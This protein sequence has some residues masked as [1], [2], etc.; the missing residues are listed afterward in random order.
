MEL[1]KHRKTCIKRTSRS[2]TK[3]L[4]TSFL[5]R[6]GEKF[7]LHRMLEQVWFQVSFNFNNSTSLSTA[8]LSLSTSSHMVSLCVF[9]FVNLFHD[10]VHSLH[11]RFFAALHR[12]VASILS[13]GKKYFEGSVATRR[14]PSRHVGKIMCQQLTTCRPCCKPSWQRPGDTKKYTIISPN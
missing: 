3:A 8:S 12:A 11:G 5:Q 14:M 7:L 4:P 10:Q 1:Q 13:K 2:Q 6:K 9:W